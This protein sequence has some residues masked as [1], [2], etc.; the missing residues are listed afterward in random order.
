MARA[1]NVPHDYVLGTGHVLFFIPRILFLARRY[2]LL[3]AEWRARGYT[4]NRIRTAALLAGI[5]KSFLGNY[6]PTENAEVVNRARIALRLAEMASR[7][8]P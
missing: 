1:K 3:C 4:V 7:G 5:D 6:S 8:K 2:K